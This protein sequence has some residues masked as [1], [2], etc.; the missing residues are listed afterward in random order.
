MPFLK[1]S[2][3]ATLA[4]GFLLVTFSPVLGAPGDSRVVSGTIEWPTT[5]ETTPFIVIRG[6]DG[7]RYSADVSTALRGPVALTV[8]S[9]VAVAGVEGSRP[10]EIVAV[11]VTPATNAPAPSPAPPAP[12]S[13]APSGEPPP[14]RV[15][16]R[17]DGVSGSTLVILTGDGRRIVADLSTLGPKLDSVRVGDEVTVFGRHEGRRFVASGFIQVEQPT[18]LALPR[19]PR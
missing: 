19:P 1:R 12:S 14:Q 9:R 13:S 18:G 15:D 16:G 10:H 5:A 6:D 8:G 2:W 4:T 7:R 11:S 3:I 17:V